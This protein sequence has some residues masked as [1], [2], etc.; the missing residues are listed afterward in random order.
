MING[1]EEGKIEALA[2]C[3]E[4]FSA[5]LEFAELLKELVRSSTVEL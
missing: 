1:W 2:F 5:K 3:V 4:I